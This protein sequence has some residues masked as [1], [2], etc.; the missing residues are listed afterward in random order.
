MDTSFCGINEKSWCTDDQISKAHHQAL[1]AST[2]FHGFG[3]DIVVYHHVL[4][5]EPQYQDSPNVKSIT[6]LAI[7]SGSIW[8]GTPFED[9]YIILQGQ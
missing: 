6:A 4:L 2:S 8:R 3:Y 9:Q 7:Q 5:P 1:A